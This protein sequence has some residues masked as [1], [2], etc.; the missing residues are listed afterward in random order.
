MHTDR[1]SLLLATAGLLVGG[2]LRPLPLWGAPRFR[3][4]PFTL[5]V[6]SG[7]PLPDG[8]VLWTRLAPE[9]LD[10]GGMPDAAV[11]VDW[12]VAADEQLTRVL[13]RGVALAHPDAAHSVHVEVEGL[14]PARVYWYRFRCGGQV[15]RT[16]RTRTAPRHGAPTEQ[17]RLAWASC[18]HFEQGYFTAYRHLAADAPDLVLHL[19]DYIYEGSWG[20]PVRRHEGPECTDLAGYRARHAR[21]KLDPD[22]QAAHAAAPWLCTWD[23]H[24]V[25]NDY[26]GAES[27]DGGPPEQFLRRRA[28]AYRAYWEHLP[29]RRR[30]RPAGPDA[31]LYSA[32]GWGD[33]AGIFVLDNRQY[34]SDQPCAEPGRHGGQLLETCAA[35]LD[36]AQTMLGPEQE[37]WLLAGLGGSR[38]RW[39]LLA[40]QML[41]APLDQKPG[42][43]SAWWTDGWDGYAAARARILQHLHSR[44]V[45]NPVVIGGDIH[46]FWANDLKLDFDDPRSPTVASEFVGTSISSR[47]VDHQRFSAMR[48]DNPHVKFF[49]SQVRGYAR[50][51]VTPK[52]WQTEF[53]SL[54]Q[55]VVTDPA[56][57]ARVLSRWVVEAGQAGVQAD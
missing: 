55:A 6:A 15:S 30:V 10:G 8:F 18:Q 46:S 28:A 11:E 23:D 13:R 17:L 54:G 40:Q 51:T 47:G 37:R 49:D 41:M 5:G 44:Q 42:H 7:D 56:A 34:R 21:Y 53:V 50:A 32:S 31:L 52:R 3:Q 24:E 12:L 39:N 57:P 38:Q 2:A 48:A 45:P 22:L 29:L 16:G 35:R 20:E 19:G 25:D 14:E 1:R 43:G 4:D 27:Q 9:P 26:A 33:L 36:P